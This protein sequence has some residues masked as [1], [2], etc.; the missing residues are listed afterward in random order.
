[1]NIGEL[2]I[3][4]LGSG[5]VGKVRCYYFGSVFGIEQFNILRRFGLS[6]IHNLH[7]IFQQ[8]SADTDFYKIYL[9]CYYGPIRATY[10]RRFDTFSRSNFAEL[11][12]LRFVDKYDPTI[13]DGP[14]KQVEVDGK[15]YFLEILDTAGSEVGLLLSQFVMSSYSF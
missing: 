2:K 1:M 4:V 15:R 13:E 12:Y 11:P 10:V 3:V 9:E 5:G 6:A 7:L 14:R 8:K